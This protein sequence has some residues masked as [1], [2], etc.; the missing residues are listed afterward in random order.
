[1]KLKCISGPSHGR[2]IEVPEGYRD[3]RVNDSFKMP[4]IGPN[5]L[6]ER[7][8]GFLAQQAMG[9]TIYTRRFLREIAN[10]EMTEIQYLAPEGVGDM[11][12]LR[13]LLT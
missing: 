1:M 6:V 3:I 9:F 11:E 5:P 13:P 12:A 4:V 10:G 8:T 7:T 2:M